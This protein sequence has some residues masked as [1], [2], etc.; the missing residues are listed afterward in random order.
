MDQKFNR[1]KIAIQE[2]L[3]WNFGLVFDTLLLLVYCHLR[4]YLQS[5]GMIYQISRTQ[6]PILGSHSMTLVLG[7]SNARTAKCIVVLWDLKFLPENFHQM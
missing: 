4:N 6:L 1:A 5:M 3:G 2:N 7:H